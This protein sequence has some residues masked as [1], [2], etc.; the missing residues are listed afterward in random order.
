MLCYRSV[1]SVY[2]SFDVCLFFFSLHL[3][4]DGCFDLR[5]RRRELIHD[6]AYAQSYS[7]YSYDTEG[8]MLNFNKKI[9]CFA[10][11]PFSLLSLLRS[12]SQT[13][14]FKYVFPTAIFVRYFICPGLRKK[15]IPLD[16]RC[17]LMCLLSLY[18]VNLFL[19]LNICC[20]CCCCW[21]QQ[22]SEFLS[23]RVTSICNDGWIVY[24]I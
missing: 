20:G 5:V 7:C 24:F 15:K 23:L 2:H 22:L 10:F 14:F 3:W 9:C 4:I 13:I 17:S 1:S 18:F 8:M 16:S 11:V 19:F 12:L 21:G 6:A